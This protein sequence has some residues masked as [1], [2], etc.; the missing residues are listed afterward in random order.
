MNY[1][2]NKVW[3]KKPGDINKFF[4]YINLVFQ[5]KKKKIKQKSFGECRH[6]IF[7]KAERN[8]SHSFS[9]IIIIIIIIIT[10]FLLLV[11]VECFFYVHIFEL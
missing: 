9:H 2:I 10:A 7:A 6:C 3:L 8:T 5:Y 11:T 4:T 1:K